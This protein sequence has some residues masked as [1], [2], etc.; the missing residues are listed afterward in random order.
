MEISCYAFTYSISC[1]TLT[2]P[3]SFSSFNSWNISIGQFLASEQGIRSALYF[4]VYITN[5][6]WSFHSQMPSF[7]VTPLFK[8]R[9]YTLSCP[10]DLR[11]PECGNRGV[12]DS[13][14]SIRCP[15]SRHWTRPWPIIHLRGEWMLRQRREWILPQQHDRVFGSVTV[16]QANQQLQPDWSGV[17]LVIL[18]YG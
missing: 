1:L 11:W 12:L 17:A 13:L 4:L 15:G 7:R 6:F 5:W 2:G 14:A 18:W 9:P 8:L 3:A 16:S 10:D